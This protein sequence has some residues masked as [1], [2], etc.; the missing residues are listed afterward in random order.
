MITRAIS[1]TFRCCDRAMA[2]SASRAGFASLALTVD[3]FTTAGSLAGLPRPRLLSAFIIGREAEC[4]TRPPPSTRRRVTLLL[5]ELALG[6]DLPF[7][8]YRN[9]HTATWNT[10]SKSYRHIVLRRLSIWPWCS[11]FL[12]CTSRPR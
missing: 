2:S 11:K 9:F 3:C 4:R 6:F 5:P 12:W 1:V 8:V 7:M 10:K